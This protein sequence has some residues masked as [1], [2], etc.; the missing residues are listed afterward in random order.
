MPIRRLPLFYLFSVVV[1]VYVVSIWVGLP[2]E[3]STMHRLT[4]GFQIWKLADLFSHFNC[5]WKV[6]VGGSSATYFNCA[7]QFSYHKLKGMLS[8]VYQM[9]LKLLVTY[10]N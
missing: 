1:A 8:C 3:N 5:A 9:D 7:V 4:F 2:V 10:L 6:H